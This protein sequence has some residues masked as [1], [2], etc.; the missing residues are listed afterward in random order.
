MNAADRSALEEWTRRA[1]A[2]ASRDGE[3]TDHE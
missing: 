2:D 3:G 1:L